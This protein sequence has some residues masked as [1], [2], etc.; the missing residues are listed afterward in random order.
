[1]LGIAAAVHTWFPE[2]PQKVAKPDRASVVAVTI[3]F[4]NKTI[5]TKTFALVVLLTK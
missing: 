2:L 1:L 4:K 3:S 5:A